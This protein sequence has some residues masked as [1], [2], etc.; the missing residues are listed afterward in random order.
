[1]VKIK[2]HQV[3]YMLERR[4]NTFLAILDGS[5]EVEIDLSIVRKGDLADFKPQIFFHLLEIE[6]SLDKKVLTNI[7][8]AV[9]YGRW[10]QEQIDNI[11]KKAAEMC[12]YWGGEDD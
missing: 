2:K 3:G 6:I 9:P 11:K 5:E 12:S 7:E 1:M 10:T 8:L 4:R